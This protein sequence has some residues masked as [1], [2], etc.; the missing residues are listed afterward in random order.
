[1]LQ[2]VVLVDRRFLDK[3]RLKEAEKLVAEDGD[4]FLAQRGEGSTAVVDTDAN[5]NHHPGYEELWKP[6]E[7]DFKEHFSK[8][9]MT[10]TRDSYRKQFGPNPYVQ[11]KCCKP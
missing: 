11:G 1:M 9:G 2:K 3:K 6:L 4:L 7:A 10:Y 8:Y 5:F